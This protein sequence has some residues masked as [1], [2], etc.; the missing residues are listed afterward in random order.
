MKGRVKRASEKEQSFRGPHLKRPYGIHVG[1]SEDQR[2]LAEKLSAKGVNISE[3]VS[4][5]AFLRDELIEYGLEDYAAQLDAVVN[6]L[7]EILEIAK[8]IQPPRYSA[9]S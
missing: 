8:K 6:E 1:L 9:N 4:R 5:T 3:L 2:R 7:Q